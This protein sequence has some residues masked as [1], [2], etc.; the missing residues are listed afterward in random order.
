MRQY[1]LNLISDCRHL[2]SCA[3][4]TRRARSGFRCMVQSPSDE[5][6]MLRTQLPRSRIRDSIFASIALVASLV[7]PSA[8]K[9]AG[10]TYE[11]QIGGFMVSVMRTFIAGEFAGRRPSQAGIRLD[12]RVCRPADYIDL[13][14]AAAS[15]TAAFDDFHRRCKLVQSRKDDTHVHAVAYP[16]PGFC[17]PLKTAFEAMLAQHVYNDPG[18]PS[19]AL[20]FEYKG[21]RYDATSR[22]LARGARLQVGCQDDGSWHVSAPR[23]RR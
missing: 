22:Q 3:Q 4:V 23:T 6:A 1:N 7:H 8:A 2:H 17:E 14:A 21:S 11:A 15:D 19:F 16:P 13:R 10:T 9:S 18:N 12:R 20:A 5:D